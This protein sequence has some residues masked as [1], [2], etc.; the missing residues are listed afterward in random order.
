MVMTT[1]PLT[2][3]DINTII[4]NKY[5]GCHVNDV[6]P[7]VFKDFV[8]F[9]TYDFYE[10]TYEDSVNQIQSFRLKKL[11][12]ESRIKLKETQKEFLNFN[13]DTKFDINIYNI[14][15][16]IIDNYDRKLFMRLKEF[17]KTMKK[18]EV[19]FTK[20]QLENIIDNQKVKH[21]KIFLFMMKKYKELSVDMKTKHLED[22]MIEFFD[23]KIVELEI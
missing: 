22:Y 3:K 4:M 12:K 6:I 1:K 8:E 17:Y 2:D 23:N 16:C 7:Y 11:D 19:I 9:Y 15:E 18:L 21:Y 10:L 13:K 5:D 14:D 20:R